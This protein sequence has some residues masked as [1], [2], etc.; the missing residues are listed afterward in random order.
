MNSI[1]AFIFKASLSSRLESLFQDRLFSSLVSLISI[2]M[3]VSVSPAVKDIA[4]A[5]GRGEK[6]GTQTDFSAF[7]EFNF[8]MYFIPTKNVVLWK[9]N[10]G[11]F[12]I[13]LW[14]LIFY[15]LFGLSSP[16]L[17]TLCFHTFLCILYETPLQR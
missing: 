6:R 1:S 17:L 12:I 3:M 11:L 4:V 13:V 5:M 10:Y 9:H 14:T 8:F 15:K 2:A 7:L 16:I